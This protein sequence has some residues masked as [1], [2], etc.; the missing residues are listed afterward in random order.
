[1]DD[2]LAVAFGYL[3]G[4]ALKEN[5]FRSLV[6]D[7]HQATSGEFMDD[8]ST[9]LQEEAARPRFDLP[10]FGQVPAGWPSDNPQTNGRTVPI[11]KGKTYPKDAFALEVR[12]DSMIGKD[13]HDGDIVVV[14]KAEA[15]DGDVVVALIDGETTLKTLVS[16]NG[17]YK[18]RSENPKH[19]HPVLT[20]QSAIQAVMIDKLG[21]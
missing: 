10:L 11:P 9:R 2:E 12:G 3:I 20:D 4:R 19:K 1:M 8:E 15:K 21:P 17:K 13:I 16:R 18:L 7:L 6:V 5:V 14:H